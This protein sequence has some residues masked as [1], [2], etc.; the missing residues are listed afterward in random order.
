MTSN[1]YTATERTP[2]DREIVLCR[3]TDR[4]RRKSWTEYVVCYYQKET[5]MFIPRQL[6]DFS[7]DIDI[8]IHRDFRWTSVSEQ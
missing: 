7:F 3:Y 8:S 1:W 2:K 5:G 4:D 6:D